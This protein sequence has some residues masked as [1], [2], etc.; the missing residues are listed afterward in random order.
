[1]SAREI[2]DSL[3]K[4]EEQQGTERK[5]SFPQAVDVV[6]KAI[7]TQNGF[8]MEDFTEGEAVAE[9]A[10]YGD[11]VIDDVPDENEEGGATK[12]SGEEAELEPAEDEELVTKQNDA[13]SR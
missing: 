6:I 1:M 8:K 10:E 9:A 2:L 4:V 3:Y 5:P 13:L 7:N 11:V 12:I